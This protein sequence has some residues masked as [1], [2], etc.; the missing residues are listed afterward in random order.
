MIK[1]RLVLYCAEFIS[2]VPLPADAI[3]NR[4]IVGYLLWDGVE[5][6]SHK[7]NA[8]ALERLPKMYPHPEKWKVHG[9]LFEH[10]NDEVVEEICEEV[11]GID[12]RAD[13]KADD[14][15]H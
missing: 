12:V 6:L 8:D 7:A 5:D 11:L 10:I 4:F 15:V 14:S 13:Y 3:P 9:I 2:K 1:K